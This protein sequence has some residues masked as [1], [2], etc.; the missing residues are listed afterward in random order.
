MP[1]WYYYQ[2]RRKTWYG[3]RQNSSSPLYTSALIWYSRRAGK[4]PRTRGAFFVVQNVK[5][6]RD[7]FGLGQSQRKSSCSMYYKILPRLKARESQIPKIHEVSR[8]ALW[9]SSGTPGVMLFSH[10]QDIRSCTNWYDH[11][12]HGCDFIRYNFDWFR[13]KFCRRQIFKFLKNFLRGRE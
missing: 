6:R 9:S 7:L 12:R 1:T 3:R 5:G 11:V 2:A 8:T 4:K 10:N 13:L